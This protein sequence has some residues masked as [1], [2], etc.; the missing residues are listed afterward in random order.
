MIEI[1]EDSTDLTD[2]ELRT[3][4][5]VGNTLELTHVLQKE[6]CSA[7]NGHLSVEGH[8]LRRRAPHLYWRVTSVCR[9]GH[10]SSR[11]FQTDWVRGEAS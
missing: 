1:P 9:Q 4:F 8:A 7:C 11:L 10:I 3:V 6:T 5:I 2:D